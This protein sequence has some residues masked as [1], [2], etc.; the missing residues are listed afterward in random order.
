V[1]I[2]PRDQITLVDGLTGPIVDVDRGP[3]D[4]DTGKP[5]VTTVYLG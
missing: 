3:T 4:P 5:M 2:D 1:S